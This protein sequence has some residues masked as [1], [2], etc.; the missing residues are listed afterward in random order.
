M[1]SLGAQL[2]CRPIQA[3]YVFRHPSRQLGDVLLAKLLYRVGMR[4][5]YRRLFWHMA[6]DAVR[7][8]RIEELIQI[9]VISHHMIT[10]ARECADGRQNAS[11]YADRPTHSPA[12]A[13]AAATHIGADD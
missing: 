2:V 3:L 5:D 9:A 11:F 7:R 8:G 6:R 10:F 1:F 4:A 12:G 13:E